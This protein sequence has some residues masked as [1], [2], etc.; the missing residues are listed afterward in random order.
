MPTDH[1]RHLG[2]DR[3]RAAQ[4]ATED[5]LHRV[6]IGGAQELNSQITL[7]TYDPEWPR[8]FEIEASKIRQAL[9]D[10]A[11]AIEHVGS[12]AVPGLSAKP[13]VDI[14]LV[15]ADSTDESAYVAELEAAGY[16]HHIRAPEWHEL[17]LFK[18]TDPAVNLHVFSAG[19]SEIDR[20]LL[21][22]DWL[23]AHPEDR[24][25]YENTKRELAQQQWKYIQHYADAKSNVIAD[26]LTRAMAST[27]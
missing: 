1:H 26:I 2:R 14:V 17:R 10:R 27:D 22:R 4:P 13:I 24:E 15:V 9:G 12:T 19:S 11:L 3:N 21:L 25:L 18:R 5:E 23:R 7:E 20:W 16:P 8:L 6:T